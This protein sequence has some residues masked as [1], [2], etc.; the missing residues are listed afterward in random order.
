MRTITALVCALAMCSTGVGQGETSMTL[1]AKARWL[2]THGGVRSTRYADATPRM[3]WIARQLI[4]ARFSTA[5]PDAVRWSLCVAE[6]E[7]GFNPGAVNSS[8]GAAGLFQ[9]LGHPQYSTWK[10]LHDPAYAV[11]AA[12]RLS[13]GGRDRSPWAGGGYTC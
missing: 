1:A 3:R 11:Q 9:F 4:T 12:W 6:R 7:S 5:G 13:Q 2:T 8:S 10:L